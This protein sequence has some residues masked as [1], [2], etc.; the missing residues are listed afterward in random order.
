MCPPA[1]SHI[2]VV[3]QTSP[4]LKRTPLKFPRTHYAVESLSLVSYWL[5]VSGSIDHFPSSA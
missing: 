1:R 5:R 3:Y 4:W 2:C